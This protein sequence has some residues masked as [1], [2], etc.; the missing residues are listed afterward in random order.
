MAEVDPTH[1]E[2]HE[3][4]DVAGAAGAAHA[5][6]HHHAPTSFIRKYVFSVDHKV[7]GIQYIFLALFSVFVGMLMSVLMRIKLTWPTTGV[8]VLVGVSVNVTMC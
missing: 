6:H 3:E 2:T 5:A 1:H 7:I 8:P 4:A